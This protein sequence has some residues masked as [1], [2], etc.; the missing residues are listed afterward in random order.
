MQY[1]MQAREG[2]GNQLKTPLDPQPFPITLAVNG[3]RGH[4]HA[5]CPCC[6]THE[7]TSG[8]R[9]RPSPSD[10]FSQACAATTKI[11]QKPT[12]WD[13]GLWQ[14]LLNLTKRREVDITGGQTAIH[15]G[16]VLEERKAKESV[17][18]LYCHFHCCCHSVS[19]PSPLLKEVK[20]MKKKI[21]RK[22]T[23]NNAESEGDR[24]T[25]RDQE[26][27]YAF[28]PWIGR[29]PSRSQEILDQI[30]AQKTLRRLEEEKAALAELVA[31]SEAAR[32][33]TTEP[34]EVKSSPSPTILVQFCGGKVSRVLK[35]AATEVK[36]DNSASAPSASTTNVL[37]APGEK[38][39]SYPTPDTPTPVPATKVIPPPP[40]GPASS[41]M[42]ST[43]GDDKPMPG[44]SPPQLSPSPAEKQERILLERANQYVMTLER[45]VEHRGRHFDL[46][47]EQLA[48]EEATNT[49]LRHDRN[50]LLELNE[51]LER[52]N[53]QLRAAWGHIE[54][55]HH[56]YHD[57]IHFQPFHP[58]GGR[59]SPSTR[60][61]TSSSTSSFSRK[62]TEHRQE[63][64]PTPI[65]VDEFPEE[66]RAAYAA[67]D[68]VQSGTM[69]K[70]PAG[71][72]PSA[73]TPPKVEM[74]AVPSSVVP[75]RDPQGPSESAQ[76]SV[77]QHL[78]MA[79]D[80]A[81]K[82]QK[83]QQPP[84]GQSVGV[85]LTG[86]IDS[87]AA[88]SVQRRPPDA[89][90]AAGNPS[91]T[92]EAQ[93]LAASTTKFDGSS[94]SSGPVPPVG[95]SEDHA[96]DDVGVP[97][98]ESPSYTSR[99]QD[100]E[101]YVDHLRLQAEAGAAR[102]RQLPRQLSPQAVES[103][104]SLPSSAPPTNPPGLPPY[105]FVPSVPYPRRDER[106]GFDGASPGLAPY[107]AVKP[108]QFQQARKA[109]QIAKLKEELAIEG[110]R[111]AVEAQR[112]RAF[113]EQSNFMKPKSI[114]K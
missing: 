26:D 39:P 20:E 18:H 94:Q 100:L 65:N 33:A 72:P 107:D 48:E 5:D 99:I 40:V 25:K 8:C 102:L 3:C 13:T 60:S 15:Q 87:T 101:R 54:E 42:K 75:S 14:A 9:A 24:Q 1:R 50:A 90:A 62:T 53:A 27:N 79:H 35:D 82:R 36:N 88:S 32:T 98:K 114:E 21:K 78:V 111:I 106:I 45:E 70:P 7:S 34:A 89:T 92:L 41:S 86:G 47:V 105:V 109:E 95:V 16:N 104:S 51:K 112:W 4:C 28:E 46:A 83:E 91:L 80:A 29:P 43:I 30:V 64:D 52:D 58:N 49:R 38:F 76:R 23:S 68:T 113:V 12:S 69:E 11:P 2:L 66:V 97:Q 44:G 22:P 37:V 31:K 56:R 61:S 57:R 55:R 63:V 67:A 108:Q 110:E 71:P 10:S 96:P 103:S 59:H 85:A 17:N 81:Q 74:A 73:E 6:G 19:S 77:M 84:Q 93:R